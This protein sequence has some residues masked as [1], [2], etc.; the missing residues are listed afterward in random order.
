MN[1]PPTW[2]G[3]KMAPQTSRTTAPDPTGLAVA[4]VAQEAAKPNTVILFG[5]RARGDHRPSSDV[6]LLLIYTQGNKTPTSR[7]KRAI[8]EYFAEHPPELGVDI[9][10]M[11]QERFAYSRRAKN[12][13][14][15]QAVRD[16]IIMSGERLDFS[17][18]YEDD[19]PDSWPDVKQRLQATYR[20][21]GTFAREFNHPEGEQE[22]YGFH[23]QQAVGNAMKAWMSAAEIDYQRIHDLEET[24]ERILN[25]PGETNTL[26]AEQLRLLMDYTTFEVPNHPGEYENWL[27][28]YAVAYRYEGTGFRMD[29]FEKSRFRQ[30]ITA[31][32]LTFVNRAH[33]LCGTDNS[34]LQ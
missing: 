24:A 7:I 30:E 28:K 12:H 34:D 20:H 4:R 21:L 10:P 14:S 9:V 31:A 15:A 25:D 11:D 27:T 13:V 3:N 22:S 23:A 2:G 6:D 8:R 5:S 18:S 32:T 19:Y 17:N 26:A 29:D 1:T 16:G 33:E